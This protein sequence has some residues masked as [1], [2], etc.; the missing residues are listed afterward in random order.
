MADRLIKLILLETRDIGICGEDAVQMKIVS[1]KK[2][3]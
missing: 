3:V 1:P 2:V